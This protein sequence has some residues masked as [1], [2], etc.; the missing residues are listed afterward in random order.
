[1]ESATVLVEK[2]GFLQKLKTMGPAAIVTAAFI[3]PGTITT[4]SIA[5]AKFGYALI[6]AMVFS[7]FATVVLQEMSARIGIVTRKGLGSALREQFNNPI[8]KYASIFLVVSAIGIGCAAYETGNILGGALGLEA[9]TGISMNVWGP[10]M[11]IGGYILLKSGNYKFVEKFLIGLVVLMSATFITTAII[12]AP[13]WS[14]ILKG[15]FIPSVP[16]GSVFL[17]MALVGTTVVP[18][19]LFLHSSA[20]QER[21]KDASG[22][23]ESRSDI[24]LSIILGG[25]ISIAVI[26]T[27]SAAFFGT[28]IA[29]NNAGDMAKSV[30]PLLGSWAKYFFAFGLFAAGLSSTITAPLAAA[31]ATAG[32]L[33]WKS[34][35][36]DKKFEAIWTTVIVIG[37][38]F[39]AMG[40]K[41]LSAIIFAQA[42]NGILL[43]IIAIFLLYAMNNKKRLGKYVN[44]PLT[45]I[46]GGIVVL[47]ACGLGLRGILRVLGVM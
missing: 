37:I 30:E 8:A 27:A 25:L 31:Y 9:V 5:G 11:G 33:G 15:M 44:S 43:P 21:W 19:N 26:I 16:K 24:F 20:V 42:A 46:L 18:Y 29:I 39:S 4:A 23:K 22:L 7:I 13:D 17:I 6:W 1:M 36:K 47:V 10:I 34:D 38:V 28:N 12:V 40:L 32:A 2:K 41:P 3:G 14:E 45:N 35:F